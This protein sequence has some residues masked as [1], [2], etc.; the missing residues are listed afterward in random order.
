MSAFHP[1]ADIPTHSHHSV[2]K[3][4]ALLA[5]IPA[6]VGGAACI[7]L[8]GVA[9]LIWASSEVSYYLQLT[10]AFV[11]LGSL[12]LA[13]RN[14]S[15]PLLVAAL[16]G[17]AM[18]AALMPLDTS[19]EIFSELA[20]Q[21][22]EPGDGEVIGKTGGWIDWLTSVGNLWLIHAVLIAVFVYGVRR[23]WALRGA[24]PRP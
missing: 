17:T 18:I 3:V 14:A 13:T 6:L 16:L 20:S 21:Q 15:T 24:K 22:A 5:L 8:L 1:F 2:M 10:L 4:L 12:F 7:F 11:L 23:W 19:V 9:Q